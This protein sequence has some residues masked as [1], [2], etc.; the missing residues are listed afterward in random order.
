MAVHFCTLANSE[1]LNVPC[2][3]NGGL[4][5]EAGMLVQIEA[6]NYEK[7]IG[8]KDRSWDYL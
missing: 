1:A 5:W 7:K 6:G 3:E 8:Y 2:L 4:R